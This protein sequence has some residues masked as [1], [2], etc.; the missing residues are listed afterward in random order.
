MNILKKK[1]EKCHE[2][3]YAQVISLLLSKDSKIL[4]SLIDR[5]EIGTLILNIKEMILEDVD[6]YYLITKYN[7][8]VDI[9]IL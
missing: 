8:P 9:E 1:L 7:R 5:I 4:S 6:N 3:I 2:D